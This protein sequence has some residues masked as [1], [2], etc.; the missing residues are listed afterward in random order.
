MAFTIRRA[1]PR[2][3]VAAVAAALL[4]AGPAVPASADSTVINCT[5]EVEL[6]FSPGLTYTDQTVSYTGEDRATSCIS[7]THPYLHSFVGP[8]SGTAT[9]S[10]GTLLD[11][12]V[13]TEILYWNGGTTLTS[14]WTYSYVAQQ[15]ASVVVYTVTG[16]VTSGVAA[17]AVLNQV[18][19]IALA[20]FLACSQPGG[21]QGYRGT[22]TWAFTG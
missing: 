5:G 6:A 19:V 10:C 12:G 15:L 14:T 3:A 8:F 1:W 18:N 17:G 13:G 21:L 2:V 7:L 9:Q 20:D 16:T 4:V 22:S 11:D